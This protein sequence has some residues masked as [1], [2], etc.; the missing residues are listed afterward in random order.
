MITQPLVSIVTP[1]F[2]SARFI[3]K[4][5]DSVQQQDYPHVEHIIV[6]GNSTDGTLEILKRHPHVTW[7]SE[8]DKGQS[9]ALNKGFEI[10]KGEI[11]GW[12]NADDTYNQ[13]AIS[14]AARFL[15]ENRNIGLIYSDVQLIDENST[16]IKILKSK[17]SDLALLLFENYIR[18]PTVF[19]RKDALEKISGVNEDLH[20]SMDR[21]FWLR[22]GSVF[23]MHY[24]PGQV[25]A[26]FR[27]Y[28]GTKTSEHTPYFHADWLK[29]LEQSLHDPL[30]SKIPMVIKQK[31]IQQ[32]RIRYHISKMSEAIALRSPIEFFHHLIFIVTGDWKHILKTLLRNSYKLIRKETA[33]KID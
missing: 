9:H 18:Q 2:N 17:S 3:E 5:I 12:L 25:F 19:I 26:N 10:A 30:Y 22:I 24:M 20:Y 31:A 8:P 32:T 29:V 33:M 23:Q 1:S 16:P 21:E 7:L 15:M 27:I 14:S 13:G 6:D 11:I 28:A 4:T